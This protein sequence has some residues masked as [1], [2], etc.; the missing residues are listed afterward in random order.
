MYVNIAL[1]TAVL[2]GRTHRVPRYPP[3]STLSQHATMRTFLG[4]EVSSVNCSLKH[5]GPRGDGGKSVC[6]SADGSGFWAARAQSS[7]LVYSFGIRDDWTFDLAM[8]DRG[9]EVHSFDPTIGERPP[10]KPKNV[11]FHPI[12][13]G[14]ADG[15]RINVEA[16]RTGSERANGEVGQLF[17]LHSIQKRLGHLG[18]HTTLIKWM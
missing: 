10:K 6:L 7:C 2:L 17:T 8:R 12:G 5:F 13:L 15:D 18:R 3:L 4:L 16:S 11:N 14:A 9:C 1:L